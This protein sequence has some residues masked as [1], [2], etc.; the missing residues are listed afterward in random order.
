MSSKRSLGSKKRLSVGKSPST[1]HRSK[2]RSQTK[3]KSITRASFRSDDHGSAFYE[4]SVQNPDDFDLS[5]EA[6]QQIFE[7]A[8]KAL[9]EVLAKK[10]IPLCKM[11]K[12]ENFRPAEFLQEEACHE[13]QIL[14]SCRKFILAWLKDNGKSCPALE[15]KKNSKIRKEAEFLELDAAVQKSYGKTVEEEPW[16]NGFFAS[17]RWHEY[18]S[19][20]EI[21]T[22]DGCFLINKW[23]EELGKDDLKFTLEEVTHKGT[24]KD[25]LHKLKGWD[26]EWWTKFEGTE[27]FK[28][29]A[30]LRWWEH[31]SLVR[32]DFVIYRTVGRGAFGAVAPC[33]LA[34]TGELFALKMINKRV[35]KGKAKSAGAHIVHA[36]QGILK[37][38][39]QKPSHYALCLRYSFQD[40]DN[41]YL[42]FQF[43]PGGDLDYHLNHNKDPKNVFDLKR[44]QFYAAETVL[45]IEHMHKLGMLHRDIKP[46]NTLL[47]IDGHTILSDF[48]LSAKTK[49]SNGK[50]RSGEKV[51]TPGYMAPEVVKSEVHD[52]G[53]DWWS[54]GVMLY[55]LH[56]KI[57]PFHVKLTGES[58]RKRASISHSLKFPDK[59][60]GSESFK[61]PAGV[62]LTED[63]KDIIKKFLTKDLKNRL[64]DPAK[65]KSHPYFAGIDWKKLEKREIEAPW[66]PPVT[67]N[68]Q[69]IMAIEEN[70]D[71]DAYKHVKLSDKDH[72]VD[73]DFVGKPFHRKDIVKMLELEYS[74]KLD[75]LPMP[76]I[77]VE[78]KAGCCT[79]I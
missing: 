56:V 12:P 71:E 32:E 27:H 20:H 2:G 35:M 37:V 61:F 67:V 58:D 13:H 26:K 5:D 54:F 4:S 73:F 1:S 47:D 14:N 64:V 29:L 78:H 3:R 66:K 77:H 75:D 19:H 16:T 40:E 6:F 48:G 31:H 69:G 50:P 22:A 18:L 59:P 15:K 65:I 25:T 79:I 38:L 62:T 72:I 51:G 41:Y 70:N 46:L 36:E 10:K 74:G 52:E 28:R 21:H 55:E 24:L 68:A 42:V 33:Q 34:C 9:Q 30:E 76:R 57:H 17:H 8:N 60:L 11:R 43:C 45:A 44:I 39:G 7:Q 49:H 23:L 63:T 53:C